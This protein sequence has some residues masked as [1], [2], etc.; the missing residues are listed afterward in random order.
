M[1]R[2][3]AQLIAVFCFQTNQALQSTPLCQEM[4]LDHDYDDTLVKRSL[5]HISWKAFSKITGHIDIRVVCVANFWTV[6]V[7]KAL[8]PGAIMQAKQVD[9]ANESWQILFIPRRYRFALVRYCSRLLAQNFKHGKRARH[10]GF[11]MP[12]GH[13]AT[14]LILILYSRT[15]FTTRILRLLEHV[16]MALTIVGVWYLVRC[17]H[18]CKGSN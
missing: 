17:F 13:L 9:D 10:G 2:L 3:E 7:M 5:H 15:S 1:H 14:H 16:C 8:T 18:T 6:L 4:R 11:T 12:L